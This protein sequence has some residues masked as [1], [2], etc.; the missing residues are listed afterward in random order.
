[1]LF[2]QKAFMDTWEPLT[3]KGHHVVVEAAPMYLRPTA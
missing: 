3:I 1:M 2:S